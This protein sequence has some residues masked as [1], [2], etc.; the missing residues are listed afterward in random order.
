MRMFEFR[1]SANMKKYARNSTFLRRW[2][3]MA[4]TVYMLQLLDIY[5]RKLFTIMT[6]MDFINHGRADMLW[7]C[8]LMVVAAFYFEIILRLWEKSGYLY[9]IILI[10]FLPFLAIFPKTRAKITWENA[11]KIARENNFLFSFEWIVICITK[12]LVEIVMLFVGASHIVKWVIQS[13]KKKNRKQWL[14]TLYVAYMMLLG[15]TSGIFVGGLVGYAVVPVLGLNAARILGTLT[16]FV[17]GIAVGLTGG[18]L[19]GIVIE[20][21]DVI[22]TKIRGDTPQWIGFSHFFKPFISQWK[23]ITFSRIRVE[24]SL[25]G[26]EPYV[27]VEHESKDRIEVSA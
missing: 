23:I 10:P 1:K 25:Y 27:F 26:V 20:L 22:K 17:S 18:V 6:G 24:K 15:L 11:K 2:G 9:L 5:P 12:L 16:G 21:I 3:L 8:I 13:M 19:V 7:S 4:L 14:S